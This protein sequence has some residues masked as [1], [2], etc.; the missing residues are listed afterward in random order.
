MRFPIILILLLCSV[1]IVT[2]QTPVPTATL[3]VPTLTPSA[4]AP[5]EFAPT[6]TPQPT[7]ID[8]GQTPPLPDL[9]PI[10]RENAQNII[11]LFTLA[12]RRTGV[13][14]APPEVR[15]VAFSP[16]GN[17]LAIVLPDLICIYDLDTPETEPVVIEDRRGFP[18]VAFFSADGRSLY[19]PQAGTDVFK[20]NAA[21]GQE[22]ATELE[23]VYVPG[24]S[25][26]VA[27]SP[28]GTQLASGT[29]FWLQVWDMAT[30][31]KLVE[32]NVGRV[33]AVAWHRDGTRL[34]TI[35]AGRLGLYTLYEGPVLFRDALLPIMASDRHAGLAFGGADGNL[36]AHSNG[37]HVAIMDITSQ[38]VVA[39]IDINKAPFRQ[40]ELV[41]SPA[42]PYL[43]VAT[44]LST[45]WDVESNQ[46]LVED[47][48]EPCVN[49]LAM[50]HAVF[51]AQGT[52]LVMTA[53]ESIL[54]CGVPQ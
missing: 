29:R 24:S 8:T 41:F 9:Q 28:D 32:V 13:Q 37:D 42:D 53:G 35:E 52:L 1:G 40:Q 33:T 14:G 4:P 21:T 39:R 30:A 36:L 48:L 25:Q 54:V 31:S 5:G 20:W 10:T 22:E 27:L 19:N 45:L 23:V 12:C 16:V 11:Q 50:D 15:V 44:G 46:S 18:S 26:N 7:A 34:A 17:R 3:V 47:A 6:P 51:N 38:D 2:A 43:L 49:T